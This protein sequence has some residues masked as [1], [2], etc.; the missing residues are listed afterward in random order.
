MSIQRYECL[1]IIDECNDG[2][3]DLYADH[4]TD[5]Q[6]ALDAQQAAHTT[7]VERLTGEHNEQMAAAYNNA[8]RQIKEL[9]AARDAAYQR[10][11]KYIL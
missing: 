7:E 10:V 2:D 8:N 11:G 9:T 6:S 1:G 4:L 5:K 3:H